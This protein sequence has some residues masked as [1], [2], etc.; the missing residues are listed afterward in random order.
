MTG[1][2]HPAPLVA[3]AADHRFA[4]TLQ[5]FL[6]SLERQGEHRR[7]RVIVYD[8]GLSD[9]DRA[10]LARRFRWAKVTPFGFAAHPP[11]VALAAG[12]YAWK[13]LLLAEL[14]DG[15][16][17]PLFWFDS[18]TIL[19]APLDQALA[20]LA[21]D[22]F[23]G[24]RSQT[25]L[26]R[27]C[28][29]RVLDSLAV[30]PEV[31]H[32]REYAAGAV[33]FD[34]ASPLGRGLV[35]DWAAHAAIA[36]H[37]VPDGYSAFH[38]H[39]QALLNCLLAKAIFAGTLTP[40]LAEVDI[41][42][43]APST[44]ISTRNYVWPRLPLWADPAAR[45]WRA[46]HKE[47]DRL[48]HV[49]SRIDNTWLDGWQRSRKEQFSV[50]IRH[51]G[52]GREVAIPGPAYGYFADPFLVAR[53]GRHWLFLEEYSFARD[54]GHLTVLGLDGD[55]RVTSSE[56]VV[57]LPDYV[58]LDTH[59]SFPCIFEHQGETYMIPETHQRGAVDLFVCERWPGRW[60]LVRRLL[61]GLDAADSMLVEEGGHWFLLTSVQG[62]C[63]NRHL[64]IHHA[65][66]LLSGCFQPHPVNTEKRYGGNRHGT[67]RNAGTIIREHG[68]TLIRI[69]QDSTN[70][71]G[72]GARA[73]AITTLTKQ[74]F[75]EEPIDK[76]DFLNGISTHH[77]TLSGPL[78]AYDTRDRTA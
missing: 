20:A 17:G 46:L 47:A 36:D 61:Y 15:H 22:G 27:K 34:L 54:L 9:A 76:I 38:K 48:Y 8:L 18:G 10:L 40:A 49:A 51:L 50:F 69:M 78:L 35:T 64:E 2:S 24:L 58:A 71:Y 59:A 67:G 21:R 43:A 12:S 6:L 75:A 28:D 45:A 23:W 13:P 62:S 57:L 60:R 14:A 74:D 26:V 65:P 29:L 63:P 32:I 7:A 66:D 5:Q 1:E 3:T 33:G 55:L 44:L 56:P 4:R 42:S 73:M 52:T 25:A 19:K 53:D 30:P 39:D 31:R 68:G 11:H 41:S 77:V 72:E 16:S 37:I 70:F